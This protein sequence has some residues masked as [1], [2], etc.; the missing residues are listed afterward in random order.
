MLTQA[1]L[2]KL[3]SWVLFQLRKLLFRQECVFRYCTINLKTSNFLTKCAW[4]VHIHIGDI[5]FLLY[6]QGNKFA[7]KSAFFILPSNKVCSL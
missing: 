6:A 2:C 3:V 1:F 5:H 7:K 4:V